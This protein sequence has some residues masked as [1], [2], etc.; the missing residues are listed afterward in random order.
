MSNK[1]TRFLV[2]TVIVA[3]IA[4]GGYSYAAQRDKV[5]PQI[6]ENAVQVQTQDYP[7]FMDF[8]DPSF[9]QLITDAVKEKL[10]GTGSSM[11]LNVTPVEIDVKQLISG[12]APSPL[13]I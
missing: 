4:V 9:D 1:I 13:V 3:L 11:H 2:P 7:G 5:S 12:E 8:Y 6:S 10:A